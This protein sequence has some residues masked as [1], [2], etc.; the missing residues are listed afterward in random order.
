MEGK[1]SEIKE[2]HARMTMD[3][4]LFTGAASIRRKVTWGFNKHASFNNS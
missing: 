2:M 1:F 3:W 4:L